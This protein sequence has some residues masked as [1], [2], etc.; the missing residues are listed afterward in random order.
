MTAIV[1][2]VEARTVT[3]PA[4][5]LIRFA[6]ENRDR[7][8]FQFV[9]YARAES[10]TEAKNHTNIFIETARQAGIPVSIVWE[11]GRF[12]RQL[13][14]R[15]VE[16]IRSLRPQLIQT[17]SVKSHF[18]L[19]RIRRKIGVPWIAFH[20]GYTAEDL[21]MRLFNRLD[22]FSLP[23]ATA[24]VTVCDAFASDL[25]KYGIPPERMR[26]LHNS[27]DPQWAERP[28][29]AEQAAAL[30]ESW[31]GKG[32]VLLCVGRFSKEK[33]HP[34]LLDALERLKGR[35]PFHLVLIGD[36][37]LRKA[38][39][40]Q[41]RS[42]QLESFVVFVGQKSDVRP[43]FKAADVLVLPSLS[44]GSPNVL[45]EAMAAQLP[46]VA[47]RAGGVCE[48]VSDADTALLAPTGDGMELAKSLEQM[49]GDAEL[50]N[51]LAS[52]AYRRLI[53]HFSPAAY[54]GKL[55]GIYRAVLGGVQENAVPDNGVVCS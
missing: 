22:R 11:R 21:K 17:H 54:D 25:T 39:E 20:H 36:G 12:D 14:H 7:F 53:E 9:T 55:V 45:L 27:L 15:L 3:G 34:I 13:L 40:E 47:T 35:Q 43:Y 48:I 44:E 5:N 10:E 4:K 50:R 6:S 42:R 26:V 41:V 2:V 28:G 18:L 51:R 52:N 19:S 37:V 8:L 31:V 33:G 29:V 16:C 24:V 23:R 38:I 49:I 46:I 30:R 32:T 1:A